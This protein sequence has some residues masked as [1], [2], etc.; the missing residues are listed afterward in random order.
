MFSEFRVYIL[1]HV[2]LKIRIRHFPLVFYLCKMTCQHAI[3][4]GQIGIEGPFMNL[5]HLR[6]SRRENGDE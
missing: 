5:R 6:I 4:K 2:M 3:V 1:S